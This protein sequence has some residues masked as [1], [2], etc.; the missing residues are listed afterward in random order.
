M[1]PTA[2]AWGDRLQVPAP[3]SF[4]AQ[5]PS[6]M[7]SSERADQMGHGYVSLVDDLM[8]QVRLRLLCMLQRPGPQQGRARP[9]ARRARPTALLMREVAGLLQRLLLLRVKIQQQIQIRR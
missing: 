1:D 6:W 5:E 7:P 4:C 8:Q 9:G 2:R 3:V